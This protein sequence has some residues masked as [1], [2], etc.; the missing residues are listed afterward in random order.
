MTLKSDLIY[1]LQMAYHTKE[2]VHDKIY[3]SLRF[4][5]VIQNT[6]KFSEYFLIMRYICSVISC[7]IIHFVS[8][9]NEHK[10]Q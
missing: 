5:T 1:F 10:H 6:L 8:A 7:A 9:I 3:S 2:L 4:V